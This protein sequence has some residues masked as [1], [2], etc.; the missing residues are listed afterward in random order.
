[1]K[2]INYIIKNF[3]I[4]FTCFIFWLVTCPDIMGQANQKK[5]LKTEDYKLWSQLNPDKI[6]NNGNWISYNL[7]YK[8]LDVDSLFVQKANDFNNKII[9]P[10]ANTGKFNAESYFACIIGDTFKLINLKTKKY[11]KRNAV[12]SFEFSSNHKYIILFLKQA[13]RK[14]GLE[15]RDMNGNILEV[16]SDIKHY[17]FEPKMNGIAYCSTDESQSRVEVITFEDTTIN[18]IIIK[19]NNIPFQNLVWK[20]D[21]IAFIGNKVNDPLLYNYDLKKKQLDSLNSVRNFGF[22]IDMQISNSGYRIPILS[23]D[24][25][26]LFFWMKES[27]YENSKYKQGEVQVWNSKDKQLFDFQKY[28]PFYTW[29]DKMA[30]WNLKEN[31][32]LQITDKELPKGFLAADYQTAFIYDPVAYEPQSRQNSPY[33]LYEVDLKTREKNLVII[34]YSAGTKPAGSPD[35]RNVCY[36]KEGQWWIYNIEQKKHTCITSGLAFSFFSEDNDRPGE[37]ASYGIAGW[38]AENEIILYDKYDLWLFSVDGKFKKRLTNGRE[39]EKSYR[40][41]LFDVEVTHGDTETKKII[42][43]L[44][45][46]F[47]MTTANKETG[48]TGL[49]Y[50]S[51]KLGAK[52]M[53]WG[54]KKVLPAG[55]AKDKNVY[56]Y[57]EQSFSSSPRLL[58][59]D[60]K[61]KEIVQ[62]NKHQKHYEW[63]KN[64]HIEYI[65]NDHKVKGVLFYPAGYKKSE[66]YPMIIYIYERQ[67]Y[68]LNEY[69]NPTLFSGDGFNVT[70]FTAH[71]YF[72]LYPDIVYEFGNL[73]ESV[74]KSVLAAVDTVI[75]KGNVKPDKLGIMGHSFGAYETNLVITQTNRFSAAVAGSAWTDLVSAYLYIGPSFRRPDFFRTENH[76]LRIGKSLYEDMPSYLNNSPVLLAKG[77]K[78]PLLGWVGEDDR[79]IH[80]LQ[81]MEFYLAL[82]RL[83]KEH[84]LLVYPNEGHEIVSKKNQ[85]D[86]SLRILKWF[87]HYLKDDPIE[88]WMQP[89]YK[90]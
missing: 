54:H 43:D 80:S 48:E 29:S 18:K 49:S 83:N 66:K 68:R 50:W 26:K 53:V 13:D 63:P 59:Y 82:R 44:S 9:F 71:G 45:K 88:N 35:G 37:N 4:R 21:A 55:K 34:N 36:E 24:G 17:C 3:F 25:S 76:Q 67:F 41:K 12:T 42:L 32:V 38:T 46:G 57:T 10:N 16:G 5:Q 20:K 51:L 72:V 27:L 14:L 2:V 52:E 7:H 70:N 75:Q 86:L 89:N 15:I 69:E 74:T 33:D 85:E 77:I 58:V 23:D 22:S 1:M 30:L 62:C 61:P 40:V 11:Y 56:M 84:T 87:N 8:N 39:T 31:K 64:E 81:T 65:V 6:S 60:S 79:H 28:I 73:R 90:H 78:T 47:L 19:N